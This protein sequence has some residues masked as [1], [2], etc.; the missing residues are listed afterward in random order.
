MLLS[1]ADVAVELTGRLL[2]EA[3]LAGAQCVAVVCPMCQMALDGYQRQ[4]E[5]QLG[6]RLDL[7]IL[8]FSQLLG[9][10]L[11]LDDRQL[12]LSRLFVSPAA[13]LGRI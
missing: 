8:Y 5:R 10:A 2:H 12:G 13:V 3:K 9:T 1:H 7:P 4:V 6:E 11:G